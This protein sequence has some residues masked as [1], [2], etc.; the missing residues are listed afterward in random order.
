MGKKYCEEMRKCWLPAFSPFPAVL[1]KGFFFR[2]IKSLDCVVMS[3]APFTE[4]YGSYGTVLT[5]YQMKNF[6]LV[7]IET[8]CKQHFKVHLK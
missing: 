5:N 2:V 7:Q 4:Q 1:A 8:N 3:Y 6:R